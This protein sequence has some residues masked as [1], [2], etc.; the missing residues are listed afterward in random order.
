MTPGVMSPTRGPDVGARSF[1]LLS[2]QPPVVLAP[3]T[4]TPRKASPC[5]VAKKASPQKRTGSPSKKRPAGHPPLP[6]SLL[7]EIADQIAADGTPIPNLASSS[8][9]AGVG[10]PMA[11]HAAPLSISPPRMGALST[12]QASAVSTPSTHRSDDPF[13]FSPP[14][15]IAAAP[16]LLPILS[17]L[18][19]GNFKD[20]FAQGAGMLRTP[21]ASLQSSP[22]M[23]PLEQAPSFTAD[24]LP[25]GALQPVPEDGDAM[26]QPDGSQAAATT[27][28]NPTAAKSPPVL[29]L[30][31]ARI[32]KGFTLEH[33]DS[34]IEGP[35]ANGNFRCL[36]RGCMHVVG[37]QE[38]ARCH[39]QTHIGD[40][41]F[42]CMVCN[43]DFVRKN[44]LKR[45]FT[46]HAEEKPHLCPCGKMFSRL[47][48]LNRHRNRNLCIGGE[49]GIVVKE[50]KRGRKPKKAQPENGEEQQNSQHA[51]QHGVAMSATSSSSGLSEASSHASPQET[52]SGGESQSPPTYFYS[53]VVSPEDEP[54]AQ[55]AA[56][57]MV[58]ETATAQ[59][60]VT[61]I[62]AAPRPSAEYSM[63]SSSHAT[64]RAPSTQPANQEIF[65]NMSPT[66]DDEMDT[67]IPLPAGFEEF[68]GPALDEISEARGGFE[69]LSGAG[70]DASAMCAELDREL[71]RSAGYDNS[72]AVVAKETSASSGA[73]AE[74]ER[75]SAQANEHHR[76]QNHFF[77][78][79]GN[80]DS[81]QLRQGNAQA[82]RPPS[83]PTV[84]SFSS[85]SSST[86]SS[87]SS[88]HAE[89]VNAAAAP[90]AG[91]DGID[92]GVCMDGFFEDDSLFGGAEDLSPSAPLFPSSQ[93]SSPSPAPQASS[94][95]QHQST[96]RQLTPEE[97]AEMDFD[98]KLKR[99]CSR[100]G[101][102]Y[103]MPW[104]AV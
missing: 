56:E 65:D 42:V 5:R 95:A 87:S 104:G 15:A 6:A 28:A 70:F 3:T 92:N 60:N 57:Q 69:G 7:K 72:P 97:M 100:G 79:N 16:P 81:E 20:P 62:S 34:Y 33:I 96:N 88:S 103:N 8:G 46:I 48:A 43:K 17:P 54:G 75:T 73:E 47:D 23:L 51:S 45:H 83:P 82:R 86:C 76:H 52:V 61:G 74:V 85:S 32:S 14:G 78:E 27:A 31:A 59:H 9:A 64:E 38:N 93:I 26:A 63:G 35:D 41:Q 11:A 80:F 22:A 30:E 40:R 55:S 98:E 18:G 58:K 25:R 99:L 101:N 53:P 84:S 50:V 36:F 89:H 24:T 4:Q 21:Q 19:A 44:D 49:K 12:P 13:V 29:D 2:G 39:V 91:S 67:Q 66:F 10:L 94:A 68:L 90:Q 102:I 1:N 77:D 71:L 37:R